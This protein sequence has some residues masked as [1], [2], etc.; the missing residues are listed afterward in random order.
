MF[1]QELDKIIDTIPDMLTILNGKHEIVKANKAMC[2]F[3]GLNK[4]QI[5]GKPCYKLMH[6]TDSPPSYCPHSILLKDHKPNI[7]EVFDENNN[8]NLY[9][10][11]SPLFN[12]DGTL[13]GSVHVARDITKYKKQEKKLEKINAILE[14]KVAARTAELEKTNI[15]LAAAN[16]ALMVLLKKS[17]EAKEELEKEIISNIQRSIL[18][19]LESLEMAFSDSKNQ[20]V[21]LDLIRKNLLHITSS[22]TGNTNPQFANLTPR[23]VQIADF[24]KHGKTTK[25]IA[26]ILNLSISAIEF[27][28]NNLREKLGIK[29]KKSNLR[30]FLNSIS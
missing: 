18:P 20:K 1:M 19:H 23:E 14:K 22:F 17:Q 13:F 27:H 6:G 29:K 28:R 15:E 10:S 9:V 26:S 4:E 8:Q 30:A 24:I 2:N 11:V 5:I 3:T 16:T 7:V 25:E 21:Y 12:N